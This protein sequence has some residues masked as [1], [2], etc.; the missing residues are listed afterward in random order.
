[1]SGWLKRWALTR[2]LKRVFGGVM[3]TGKK[4][5]IVAAAMIAYAVVVQGIWQQDWAA[6]SKT[7]MEAL[8]IAGLRAG[9]S[10][11]PAK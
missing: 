5:Y 7:I 3:L 4:T 10:T 9:V 11:G 1:V 6:A 8:A 2:A